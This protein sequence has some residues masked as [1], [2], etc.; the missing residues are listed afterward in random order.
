MHSTNEPSFPYAWIT[1]A[2][3]SVESDVVQHKPL[4]SPMI[5]SSPT[6]DDMVEEVV[7]SD[8]DKSGLRRD[9][10]TIIAGFAMAPDTSAVI[11]ATVKSL[12]SE[13]S[14]ALLPRRNLPLPSYNLDTVGPIGHKTTLAH[15]RRR[16]FAE[17]AF[18]DL[19]QFTRS[20]EA[21][22]EPRFPPMAHLKRTRG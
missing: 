17:V 4:P 14:V 15:A 12:V 1:E 22:A 7:D 10:C 21:V 11:A 9:S 18:E 19:P 2:G 6:Q 3:P 5:R 13:P 16:S 20:H 8:L